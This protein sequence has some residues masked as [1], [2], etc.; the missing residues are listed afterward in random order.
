VKRIAITQRVEVI[1]SYGERRDCLDQQWF[2]F[3][4]ALGYLPIPLPNIDKQHARSYIDELQLDGIIFSGGNSIASLN[5]HADDAAPERDLFEAALLEAAIEKNIPVIGVCR[6]M[7]LINDALN[8]YLEKIEG[9]VGHKHKIKSLASNYVLPDTVNSFHNYC[10]PANGL[11]H[12]L[13]PIATDE[14]ENIEA[15]VHNEHSILG[16]MWHPER[17]EKFSPLDIQLIKRTLK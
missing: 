3:V 15:F 9:H 14:H 11:A 8:G 4:F 16:M 5:K 10:I 7:Q 2:N 6:G 13:I 1:K 12:S 17:E